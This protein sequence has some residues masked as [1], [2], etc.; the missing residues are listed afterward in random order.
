V[1][2]YNNCI[3]FLTLIADRKLKK[4][5]IN[6]L[7]ESRGHLIDVVYAKGSVKASYFKDMLGLV[8]EEKK[9]LI[10]CL[11]ASNLSEHVLEQLILKFNFDK[12][13]TGIA[14]VVPVDTLSV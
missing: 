14:F 6:F 12:P 5:I 13:N 9:I 2:E 10:T 1:T 7:I 8:P 4:E 11:I 3:D